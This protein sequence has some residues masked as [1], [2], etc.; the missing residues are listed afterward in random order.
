MRLLWGLIWASGFFALS[1]QKPRLLLFSPSVVRI[2]VPL[3]VAV[4][5]QDAPSGQVVRGSVFLR[6]PSHVNELCSLKVD[7]SLSSDR[8]FILLNLPI[9]QEQARICRLHLLR[10][11]PEV[12]LMVQSSWLRDSLSKQTDMQ[13]VNLLFSSRR[14]HLFLQTDQP[15]YNPG[16]RVRYRVFA[17]DQKM[18]PATDILTVTVENSQGFRV[19]KRE[20]VV[21]SS[22]FQDNF[23]I[24]D[25]SEP[26]TWK[27]SARF[28]DSLDSNSSTQ[29]E[30]KKY[31]LPNFEVKIIPENPYI[32]TT[33]GFL[34]DIQVIIQARYIYGKPVQGVAYV[35]FG[36]LGEDGEKTFLRGLESQTKLVSGQCQISLQKAEFQGVLEKLHISINDLPGLRLYVAAAVIESPGGELE[37]AELT[38]WRFVSSPFSLDLSK[39]KQQLI[40][41]VPFLLQARV[42]DMSGSPASGI[43]VKVSAKLFSGSTSKNED[44]ERN[45]DES[46]QVIVS[47]GVPPTISEVQ[48]S[49]SA[50]SPHPAVGGLTVKAPL[51]RSSGFLSIEWR[52]PRPLKV[53]EAL[54]LNLQ[55]VGIS[56]SFSHFYYMILSRG[57]IVSV[58]REPKRHL[59]SISVFVDHHLVPSFHL[60]A[61]YYHGGVPVANSL[62]VDVQAGTCEGKLEL[63]VD[64]SKA[65]RPGDTVKLTLQTESRALVA[66]GAVD[67]ALYAVGGKSHKPLDMVKVFEAMNSYDLGCGP[68]G[69]DSAPQVFKAAGL[70]FSDG[71]HRT[72][73]RKSLSCPKESK[74][75]KKRNVNF[76]KAINEKLGQYTSPV[77]KRCCQDGLTRLPMVRTCE[78]RADRVQPLACREPFLSCCQFAESLRKKAWTRGQVGLA[79]AMELLREED[80]IE[81]DDIPVRSFFPENWLWKVEEVDRSSQLR[82]LLP[83]SLTTWEIHG[84]SLSKRTGLCVATPARLRVFREFHM[85]LRLPHSVRR[86]EQLELRPVLY[87]Y[88][89]R[90]LT[91]SVHVSPVEG[92]CLAG[93]GGLAQQVQVPAGSARPVGFSVVPIAAA[94]VSLKVVA[95]GSLDF[96]VGDAISKILH[97][98]REGAIHREE[99]VYELNP[100]DPRGR[101]LEIPGNSD[102]NI[103]PEGDFKSVVR[104]TA[105]DPLEALGSEGALSPGG[106]ASLLRLPQGCGEQ[107]MTLLAPTLAASRYLDK[108]EQ[109]SMLPP[110][111]KDRAVDLI[112]KGYTR[113]QEFRKRDGSYGAW[114]HRDS[115]TWLTAF[116]L[117]ILS[118]AQDQVGGSPEKLQETAMWLLS[119]QR[120][121]GSFHDP[122]PVIHREMQ[123]GLVGSDE[124]VAL[125]AFVVIALHH[126]LAVFPDKNSEQLR[127]VE[128]SISRANTFLGAKVTSGLLGS[129]ASAITAYALSLTEAPED[130]QSVA[131][132]NLMAMAQDIGDKLY[133]GSVTTS[134]S[135]VLSPTLAPRSPADPIPQVPAMSIETTAYGLL[136][137]LLWE[138]KAELADQAA[139]WLSRQG[140][141][142]GGYRSTQDT[143]MALDALSAYWIASH[144]TEEKGLNVTLSSLG[145]SGLKSHV[146]QLTNHQVHR[147]EEE[148]QFS[149]G[150]KINVE[151]GGNSKGTL[152]VL[153]SYNVMDMTNTTCQD[154][155]VEVTVVG[156]VEYTMEAEEDYQEYEYEDS[157]AGD[158]PEA[159]SRPVTPLQLFDGRRNR[160]RREAPKAAEERESRVQYSVCIWRTGKVGLSGMAI[161]DITLLSGFHALRADLEKLTSLSD[162]YVSHFETEGPHVLLYFD[163]VPTSRECVGFGAVQEVPVG[164]VQP[165][166]AVLYDYYNPEHKCSVFYGAPRKSKLLSTLCSADVCQCAEGKCP[167]QRRALER[168]QQD[169][170]GYRMKFACYSPRVDYAFQVKVLREDSRAAF[171]LFETHITQVLH[172]TKDAKATADQTRNFLVRASCRLQLEP[173][174]EYLIMGLDGATYDLK[175]DPQY[176]LDSNSWIEEMPSKRMCQ[177]TRHRTPCAQLNSFLEEYGTQGCQV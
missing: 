116:V 160:R 158:D 163:S 68:G 27:I 53:G 76:Q 129:H 49:V 9:P 146:L 21:P 174:K 157:P 6:N 94:A 62:R 70:A 137:L 28:S 55:A 45:T 60:V 97:V 66:L 85:H 39:T 139:S 117:K 32:L 104:V 36:L 114:L 11:A 64:S 46:G 175:G 74:P 1:L 130:L 152:K 145:R 3:S 56:G 159:H 154:L 14:G 8:D 165:A 40:P 87:N 109:W 43:P 167:R 172:F 50:G 168:G 120:D 126:G 128:N 150:S 42:R 58:H 149:L 88:L 98:E 123:G 75:R 69:G 124:T 144:T 92:L 86:F 119:Q 125:T 156:H 80:L 105:S 19:Q 63:N 72:E 47:I 173:G 13:G 61:F 67:T 153:R 41:G 147:L 107:T 142:Q 30:V 84:M 73:I 16:Q 103:I 134:P 133:W 136:H 140:S 65:Y 93:G 112:Q 7:F 38:S 10:G 26:G 121:D 4:K 35:R 166:S 77:A 176:L 171:R 96:P 15:V 161:A 164:L 99:M 177:S 151:V 122:C 34:S 59:T 44:F 111:T 170:E 169:V 25:I 91:V 5:L 131:H 18:R 52:N 83:D 79:R 37:E 118:L 101:T 2:G 51:S 100:L 113:I 138:G 23:L 17:L 33:P 106:V 90:D 78:Q 155:Q 95:R 115:S 135:N 148:L 54:N 12:Q 71:D 141:F 20:V 31:V 81:E 29:F 22:I 132:N 82:L 102:P 127:R 143:V 57:Q 24:P 89:D 48:L 110:E 108:T 162:R